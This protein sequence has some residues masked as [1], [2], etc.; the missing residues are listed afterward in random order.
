MVDHNGNFQGWATF[1]VVSA[2][3]GPAKNVTGYFVS[4]FVNQRLSVGNC[5]NGN[6]PR[7]LG[8]YVLKL[9]N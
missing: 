8:S 9:T 2:D 4:P 1:H 3:G 5:S 6:C 7:F